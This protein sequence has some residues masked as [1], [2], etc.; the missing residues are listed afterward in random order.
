MTIKAK[1]NPVINEKTPLLVIAG[2]MFLELF[3]GTML[4]N[5]DTLM[6]SHYDEYAV[7][8]VGNAN[9]IMFMLNILFNIIATATGV[10]VAQYLG[11]KQYDKMNT[12]YSLAVL[13][14]ATFGIILSAGIALANPA[15]MMLFI[16]LPK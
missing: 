15:F 5:I 8:A 11:A 14:N 3:L 9:Q 2:P 7:G 12:I 6:L 4:N 1:A 10:V 16:Y 13:F